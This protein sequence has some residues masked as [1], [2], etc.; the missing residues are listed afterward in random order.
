[1]KKILSVLLI[2]VFILM[3][4]SCKKDEKKETVTTEATETEEPEY[5]FTD[6]SGIP[7]PLSV[8]GEP[9]TYEVFRYYYALVKYKYDNGDDTYWDTHDYTQDISDETMRYLLRDLATEK[10]AESVG[11]KLSDYELS[12]VKDSIQSTAYYYGSMYDFNEMLDENYLTPA[13]YEKLNVIDALYDKL[14]QYLTSEESGYKISNDKTL[15]RRYLDNYAARADHI[16]ILNDPG[17]NESENETLIKD[18]YQRIQNGEDF[19]LLKAQYSEDTVTATDTIGYYFTEGDIGK[20]FE[21][22]ALSLQ[23]GEMSGIIKTHYGWH[24]IKRLPFD[25]EYIAENWD[26][27]FVPFYQQHMLEIAIGKVKDAMNIEYDTSFYAFTPKN[28]K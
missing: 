16:L 5:V 4:F 7:S 13:L 14:L 8:D 6:L 25:E 1:M 3:L 17:D 23:I 11:V 20:E 24:I 18:I 10:Y 2:T 27:I 9:V 21:E 22:A 15:V 26:S 28:L 19:D 12:Q